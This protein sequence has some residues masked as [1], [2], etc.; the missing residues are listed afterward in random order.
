M[1]DLGR[2]MEDYGRR[3]EKLIVPDQAKRQAMTTAGA[4]VLTEA[5]EKET[6]SRHYQA[7]RKVGK[8][9]HLADSVTYDPTDVDG[10]AN[11]NS[12]V[13]FSG[14]D[15]SGINH[16]RIARFLND[17]TKFIAGDSFVDKTNRDNVDAVMAAEKAVYDELGGGSGETA[18]DSGS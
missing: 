13:G 18:D 7:G 11:G 2:M 1:A 14:R 15:E 6:R 8:V 12:V 9:K 5:L 16:G 17:G 4:K 10:V 3:A